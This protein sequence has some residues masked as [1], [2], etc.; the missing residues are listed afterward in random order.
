MGVDY[1]TCQSCNTGYRDDSDYACYCDCG[2][3][4]C[5]N[6]CGKLENFKYEY[7]DED[8]PTGVDYVEGSHAIDRDKPI[9]CIMCRKEAVTDYILLNFLL[10]HV[11]MTREQVTKLYK[12][13]EDE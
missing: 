4:Y 8:C 7:D 5:N 3:N 6:D 2:C 12:E 10:K 11:N 9:T 13:D 1:F